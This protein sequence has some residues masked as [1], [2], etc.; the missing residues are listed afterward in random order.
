MKRVHFLLLSLISLPLFLNA[1]SSNDIIDQKEIK[2]FRYMLHTDMLKVLVLNMSYGNPDLISAL[3]RNLLK[4]A[5]V[6]QID[7]VFSD[8]P[9]G[10]DLKALNLHRIKV[11]ESIRPDL[12]KDES[13]CWKIIRQID[14]KN[15][16]EAKTLFHGIVIHYKA[17]QTEEERRMEL[18]SMDDL[19]PADSLL[20]KP[21]LMR[22]KLRDSTVVKVL[23]RKKEWNN[24]TVVA[25][26]TGSMSPYVAQVVLWFHLKLND[27]RIKNLV[28]FNDGDMKPTSAKVIGSTGGIYHSHATSYKAARDLAFLTISKGGGGDCPEND[29]EALIHAID[30]APKSEA[31]ILVA[32][33]NSPVKDISLLKNV[34]KPVHII[35]CG[36]KYGVNI[37]YIKIARAT[38]GSV[39]TMEADL[40]DLKKKNEGEKFAF[41]G[42]IYQIIGGEVV[43]VKSKG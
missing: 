41:M 30:F 14:C 7:L 22:K 9:K 20:E 12:V 38:G 39:H 40:E 34:T 8:F 17:E 26:M 2:C 10:E 3:D 43:L 35:L 36:T 33:N 6:R 4:K 18:S 16:G 25:D 11:L 21:T 28:F 42:S 24:M 37:E 19:L 15:E 23:E 1:R 13:I 27:K 29:M 5:D 31:F 32:D